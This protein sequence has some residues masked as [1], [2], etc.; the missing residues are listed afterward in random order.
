MLEGKLKVQ[1]FLHCW[2]C[3]LSPLSPV[4]M[5]FLTTEDGRDMMIKGNLL[6][7]SHL[8]RISDFRKSQQISYYHVSNSHTSPRKTQEA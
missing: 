3:F 1:Y 7:Y 2:L 8:H 6:P 4:T 5:Y